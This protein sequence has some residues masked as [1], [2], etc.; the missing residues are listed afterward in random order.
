MATGFKYLGIAF[1]AAAALA[2]PVAARGEQLTGMLEGPGVVIHYAKG[3]ADWA[4]RARDLFPAANKNALH[5][6]GMT[7]NRRVSIHL[8]ATTKG[9]R[10]ATNYLPKDTLGVAFPA[11]SQIAIDCSKAAHFG[12][13]SFNL[14]LRHEM[15]HIAF[16]RLHKRTGQ[17]VPL[18]FNEG[19]ACMAMGR[20]KLGD[21]RQLVRAANTGS[22]FPLQQ[23]AHRFPPDRILRELA[24]QQAESTATFLIEKH[25]EE[26]VRRI[27]ERMDNG[28]TF[29]GALAELTGGAD[30]E[31]QWRDYVRRRYPL[32]ALIR[33]Y[34]SLFSLLALFVIFAYIVYRFRRRRL[35]KRWADEEEFDDGG[36]YF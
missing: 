32:L 7:T 28:L 24:Y 8:Y 26:S 22:L 30:F 33:N 29:A 18:W 15:I 10:Q 3:T 20:L 19:V 4:K 23:L 16:G 25:G 17:S 5:T 21:P 11:A 34:F 1:L 6:L 13:N 36:F 31:A 27:V 9:F 35:R 12:N 2:R 14:T